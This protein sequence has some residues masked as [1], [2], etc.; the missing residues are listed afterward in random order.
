MIAFTRG[1]S[2]KNNIV[3]EIKMNGSKQT[4]QESEYIYC[5]FYQIVLTCAS[6]QICNTLFM[7]N[8]SLNTMVLEIKYSK[9][10]LP[11]SCLRI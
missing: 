10:V 2:F 4:P 11:F 8:H 5:P 1:H 6:S 7:V 9:Y 3:I